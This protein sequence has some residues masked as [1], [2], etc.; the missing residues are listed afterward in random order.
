MGTS[1]ANRLGEIDQERAE[2][3]DELSTTRP[4]S[5]PDHVT[6][7]RERLVAL[8]QERAGL[9]SESQ[10]ERAAGADERSLDIASRARS[11]TVGVWETGLDRYAALVESFEEAAKIPDQLAALRA[12]AAG[13]GLLDHEVDLDVPAWCSDMAAFL[14]ELRT[15]LDARNQPADGDL[16]VAA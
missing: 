1:T 8:E 11:L 12:E 5:K 16:D 7:L 15:A 14:R 9:D 4:H 2:I 10:S 3:E 6:G 13:A